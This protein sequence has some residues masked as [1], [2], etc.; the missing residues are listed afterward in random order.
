[1]FSLQEVANIKAFARS[2]TDAISSVEQIVEHQEN[3][4]HYKQYFTLFSQAIRN[5]EFTL[6]GGKIERGSNYRASKIVALSDFTRTIMNNYGFKG[7]STA[8][9][10]EKKLDLAIAD[11]EK[12]VNA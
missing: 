7:A 8:D 6:N 1:M 4:E 11:L 10:L 3:K 5:Q 9:D 12:K 2:F